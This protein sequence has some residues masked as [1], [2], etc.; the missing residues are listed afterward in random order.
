MI[1]LV[2]NKGMLGSEV[3]LQLKGKSMD[4]IGSDREVDITKPREIDKF[5]KNHNPSVII[6]CAAYTAVDK[7]EDDIETVFSL[8]CTGPKNLAAAAKIMNA[9]LIHISTD[10]VFNGQSRLPLDESSATGPV[11]VY[12]RSKLDG[13]NAIRDSGCV[14]DI[15]RTA[16]LYGK[17]GP[18]FV[19]TMLGLMKTKDSLRVVNDQHGTPTYAGDLAE[20]L[21]H[22]SELPKR[23]SGIYHFSNEGETTWFGFAQSI[24][25]VARELGI[26]NRSITIDPC[27]SDEYPTRAIRPRYS[28][29]SKR[30]IK[31][32]FNWKVPDWETSLK[33]YFETIGVQIG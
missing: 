25:L 17:H 5:I 33:R 11:S 6:N 21:V 12:G 7:A 10:Y 14:Y 18:N 13:E 29:L 30:T 4:F 3:A 2:G 22:L 26:L 15:V 8:N 32:S 1:W 27:S 31:K 28:L 23:V 19:E 16:W 20:F 24:Y 9:R